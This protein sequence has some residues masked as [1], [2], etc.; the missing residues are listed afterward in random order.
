MPKPRKRKLYSYYVKYIRP[1]I[2][3]INIPII[4]IALVCFFHLWRLQVGHHETSD[5]HS[6]VN[7]DNFTFSIVGIAVAVMA[8][9]SII[10]FLNRFRAKRLISIERFSLQHSKDELLSLAS[11]QLRTPATAVKQYLGMMVQG[12][13]GEF[14]KQQLDLI[15]RAYES[16]ERQI[17]TIN[18]ILYVTRADAHRLNLQKSN[19]NLNELIKDITSELKPS[20]KSKHQV[21][22]FKTTS[23][24]L[25]VHA[26]L[27]FIR[28]VIENLLTNARKYTHMGGRITVITT[29]HLN[30]AVIEVKD[31]GVGIKSEDIKKLFKKFSR[32][33]NDLSI[34]A[35][36][37]GI[38]L[39]LDKI[40]VELHGGTIDASSTHGKGTVFRVNLPINLPLSQKGKSP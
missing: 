36:G 18:Q 15:K 12:Y 8:I 26:D 1:N 19:F 13:A 35:G 11:H 38:G 33:D 20:Y 32:I 37:S 27:R 9:M 31:N 7:F 29:Q 14:S 21:L 22:T 4:A 23:D 25:N 28:I 3:L 39:Y 10:L 16:N 6:F 30:T 24:D 34:E 2:I 40:I 5:G 17:D